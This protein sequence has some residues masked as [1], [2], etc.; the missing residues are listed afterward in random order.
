MK[1]KKGDRVVIINTDTKDNIINDFGKH[2]F[3]TITSI[4]G[5]GGLFIRVNGSGTGWRSDCFDHYKDNLL[6][7]ELFE[8]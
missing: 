5:L 3:Y 2:P 4:G 1:F 8:L 6:P 7:D